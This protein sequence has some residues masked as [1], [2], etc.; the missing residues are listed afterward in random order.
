MFAER[1]M[2]NAPA[3]KNMMVESLIVVMMNTMIIPIAL[4]VNASQ[5][6]P[7]MLLM[8]VMKKMANAQAEQSIVIE[9]GT[10][11]KTNNKDILIVMIV[12]ALQI[13]P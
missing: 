9:C 8:F 2:A 1:K 13:T 12:D 4:I 6:T 10:G 7:L 11:R 3:M 5:T